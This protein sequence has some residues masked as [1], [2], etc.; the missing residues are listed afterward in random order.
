MSQSVFDLIELR[1]FASLW[2]WLLLGLVWTRVIHAPLGV[3]FDL[4]RRA[5][6]NDA[7]AARDVDML[8]ELELRHRQELA[9]AAGPW[10]VAAWAFALSLL[11]ILGIGYGIELAQAL[12]LL[13]APLAGVQALSARA[14]TRIRAEALSG[15]PLRAALRRLRTL[16]QGLGMASVFFSALWGMYALLAERAF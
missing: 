15:A 6:R 3:P 16:V 11:A 13:A 2:Y 12:L 1:A 14:R 5:E 9:D 4:L 8:A 10:G 7:Q